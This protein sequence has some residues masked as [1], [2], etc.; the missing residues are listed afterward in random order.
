[1]TN[2]LTTSEAAIILR[3]S[4][5]DPSMLAMLPGIDAFL[6]NATGHAWALDSE[7]NEAAKNAARMLLVQ[8]HENPG[9]TG[10]EQPLSFGL[11]ATIMQLKTIAMLYMEFSGREGA[12]SCFL[13]YARRGDQV[14][15]LVLL[16][17]TKEDASASF[18]S[19]ISLDGLILQISEDDLSE[20]L[21]RAKLT[22][23]SDL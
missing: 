4:E 22:P 6:F 2:I 17:G 10:S 13:P 5:D 19:V 20:N 23:P 18:E 3:C 1:M 14:D 11:A 8:W 16:S 15:S 21:Y 12:G 7:I 9:M